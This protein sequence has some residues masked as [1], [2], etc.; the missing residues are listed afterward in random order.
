MIKELNKR[1]DPLKNRDGSIRS[2]NNSYV[3]S[4][5]N[6]PNKRTKD[7]DDIL[8]SDSPSKGKYLPSRIGAQELL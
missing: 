1:L 8:L 6:S 4:V 5:E 2:E 3:R 7:V